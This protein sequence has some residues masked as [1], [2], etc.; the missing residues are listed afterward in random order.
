[1]TPLRHRLVG[2]WAR[3][4]AP[5]MGY[6]QRSGD[7]CW[8]PHS[9]IGSHTRIDGRAGLRLGDHVYIG[10]FTHIDAAGGLEI[11]DGC[12]ITSHVSVLTHSS[13]RALR[14]M[15]EAYWG[16]PAPAGMARAPVTIGAWTFVGPHSV[17]SPGSRIGRGVLVRAYSLVRG[18]VPDFAVVEGQPARVVGDTRERDRDWLAAH[19]G[20]L[21]PALAGA[22]AAWSGGSTSR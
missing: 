16:D 7:G 13:H 11:G 5:R 1:M 8:R 20:E 12:Q 18:E 4:L 15:R 17:I 10:Q 19:A 21:D 6:G 22:W 9:R 3:L 2:L 14:L